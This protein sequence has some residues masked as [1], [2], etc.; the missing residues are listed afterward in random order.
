M[1]DKDE[2][3]KWFIQTYRYDYKDLVIPE[4]VNPQKEAWQAACEYMRDE[5]KF[6]T[7]PAVIAYQEMNEKLQA[8]NAELKTQIYVKGSIHKVGDMQREMTW[9]ESSDMME[10]IVESRTKR[11]EEARNEAVKLHK[12]NAKLLEVVKI[13][14]KASCYTEYEDACSLARQVL[15]ELECINEIR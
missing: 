15:K 6:Q 14:S 7:P 8:E 13:V 2:F 5:F 3:D 12:E 10:R 1:N 4:S 11:L 9:K